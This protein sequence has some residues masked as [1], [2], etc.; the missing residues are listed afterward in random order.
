MEKYDN[1]I[2]VDKDVEG[3][4]VQIVYRKLYQGIVLSTSWFIVD[5][6]IE[7]SDVF[8]KGKTVDDSNVLDKNYIYTG[9][10]TQQLEKIL[11]SK[12]IRLM[13]QRQAWQDWQDQR[14]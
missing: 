2:F 1:Y 14:Q 12:R 10:A 11:W 5:K 9:S 4:D 7:G 6:D 3:S 13:I 8:I